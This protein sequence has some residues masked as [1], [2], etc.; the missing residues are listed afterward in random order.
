VRQS[1]LS[2]WVSVD[3]EWARQRY[4]NLEYFQIRHENWHEPRL[5]R[6]TSGSL[7]L[8]S[9]KMGELVRVES[10]RAELLPTNYAKYGILT[11]PSL[12][13]PAPNVNKS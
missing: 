2:F 10:S 3:A 13:V 4:P 6:L 1:A 5:E 11:L 8:G 12:F 7:K 9:P